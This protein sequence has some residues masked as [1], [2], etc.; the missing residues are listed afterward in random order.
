MTEH[1][2]TPWGCGVAGRNMQE[3]YAQSR[4]VYQ[5]GAA[6]LVAGCFGDVRGGEAVA[7]ANSE[8]IVRAVNAHNDLLAA[9]KAAISWV[10][11]DD[12][13]RYGNQVVAEILRAAIAKAKG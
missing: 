4:A 5:Q 13:A 1:T 8:F 12:A 7:K 10:G 3:K 9:C 2:P 6:N 11:G